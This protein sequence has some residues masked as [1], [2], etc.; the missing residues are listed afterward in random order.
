MPA[1]GCPVQTKYS[2]ACQTR[3][4]CSPARA[5]AGQ[6]RGGM[7]E[8]LLGI[9]WTIGDVSERGSETCACSSG[10]PR[11][12]PGPG[13][14]TWSAPTSFRSRRPAPARAKCPQHCCWQV[15][16]A[17]RCLPGDPFR[18]RLGGRSGVKAGAVALLSGSLRAGSRQPLHPVADAPRFG[19]AAVRRHPQAGLLAEDVRACFGQFVG[20][21][22]PMPRN[23]GIR[24]L[25]PGFNLEAA[26]QRL[27][28]E[29]PVT[30]A[31]ELDEQGLQVTARA[32]PIPGDDRG[33]EHLF[34]LSAAPAHPWPPRRPFRRA[35]RH[36]G[37]WQLKG[38]PAVECI[39]DHWQRHRAALYRQIGLSVPLQ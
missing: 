21:C 1:S 14:A 16:A 5:A 37:G 19:P 38:R 33:C 4:I 12:R 15:P 28:Q 17:T 34:A 25:P 22:G 39:Q 13:P 20:L 36:A 27:L 32:R 2:C 3:Q 11:A 26:L 29:H 24:G 9:R 10:V 23:S 35:Q 6:R 31:S 30:L 7:A 8:R 18:W